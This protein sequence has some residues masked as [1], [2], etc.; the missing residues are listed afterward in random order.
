[1]FVLILLIIISLS[2]GDAVISYNRNGITAK[3]F[4]GCGYCFDIFS[5]V[6]QFCGNSL[7]LFN[8]GK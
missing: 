2:W 1:M 3:V 7:K 8:K 6:A 4:F 5:Q